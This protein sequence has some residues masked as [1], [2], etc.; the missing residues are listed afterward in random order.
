MLM[1]TLEG[2]NFNWKVGPDDLLVVS[3][4]TGKADPAHGLSSGLK[5]ISAAH[6]MRALTSLMDDCGDMVETVMQWLSVSPT[7][8]GARQSGLC[9]LRLAVDLARL[10]YLR[11]NVLFDSMWC[12]QTLGLTRSAKELKALE[13]MDEP[14]NLAALYE[15]G[16]LAGQTLI[17]AGHFSAQFDAGVK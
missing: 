2:F 11:Y 15:L 1:A 12:A 9:E 10:S 13:A 3:V 17:K 4:G 5:G 16:S 7:A 8:R 6:A 14:D